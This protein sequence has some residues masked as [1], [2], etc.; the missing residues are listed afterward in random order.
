MSIDAKGLAKACGVDGAPMI[1][2][3][4]CRSQLANFEQALADD[5]PLLVCCT[6]EAPLFLETADEHENSPEIRFT[7]IRER[8]GWSKSGRSNPKRLTPKLA[9]LIREATLDIPGAS[10]VTMSSDGILLILGTDGRAIEAAHEVSDRLDVTVILTGKADDVEPPTLM[11]VPV[12]H[13]EITGANGHLGD[14]EVGVNH[15][16]PANPASIKALT[17]DGAGQSGASACDLILDLRGG[18]PLFT[19]PEKRDGYFNPE[20]TRTIPH[21]DDVGVIEIVTI[22]HRHTG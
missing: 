5:E 4:L 19:A 12:F 20:S 1:N 7:N 15:F 3:Q 16:T 6:Q 21:G 8:A 17:F 18:A 11:D 13:G 9:A 22:D 2:T 14:F 10:S